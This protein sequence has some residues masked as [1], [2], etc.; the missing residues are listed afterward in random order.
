M[1]SEHSPDRSTFTRRLQRLMLF[2]LLMLPSSGCVTVSG[3][4]FG[5]EAQ[6]FAKDCIAD[7]GVPMPMLDPTNNFAPVP[8]Q[9]FCK[10][11]GKELVQTAN[12]S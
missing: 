1:L 3:A 6:R 7:N 11:A 8:N 5:S 4:L 10:E 2:S 9:Y 12:N